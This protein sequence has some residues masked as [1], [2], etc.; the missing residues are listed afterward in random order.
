MILKTKKPHRVIMKNGAV[1]TYQPGYVIKKED[2][3]LLKQ[4]QYHRLYRRD[5]YYSKLQESTQ[6]MDTKK[7]LNQREVT[8]HPAK[9]QPVEEKKSLFNKFFGGK[10]EQEEPKVEEPVEE[11]N[12][13]TQPVEE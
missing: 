2:D 9:D 5:I 8:K 7:V 11:K 6:P 12:E 13:T 3:E 1:K 10:K 4:I